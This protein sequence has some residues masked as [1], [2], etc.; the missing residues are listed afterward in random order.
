MLSCLK[1]FVEWLETG[2]SWNFK[3]CGFSICTGSTIGWTNW[4]DYVVIVT[5]FVMEISGST[6][7]TGP[8]WMLSIT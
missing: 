8:I 2:T 1:V 3:I 7:T 4:N 5:S 6:D